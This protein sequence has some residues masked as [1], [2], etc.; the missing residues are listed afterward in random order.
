MKIKILTDESEIL[1]KLPEP[2]NDT[3]LFDY[4]EWLELTEDIKDKINRS[5]YRTQNK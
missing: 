4:E 5:I 1:I 2:I 3:V